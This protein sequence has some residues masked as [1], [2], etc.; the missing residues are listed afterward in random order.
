[1]TRRKNHGELTPRGDVNEIS[2]GRCG[3]GELLGGLVCEGDKR[4]VVFLDFITMGN[5][6]NDRSCSAD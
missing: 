2:A 4:I 1:L 5:P 6:K 3:E